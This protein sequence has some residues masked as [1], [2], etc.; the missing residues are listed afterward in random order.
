A[1]SGLTRAG[2]LLVIVLGAASLAAS[3]PLAVLAGIALKVGIDIIDWGFLKRAHQISRKGALIMYG[4]I[5][6]TVLVDL[7]AAVGCGSRNPPSPS[8]FRP[9]RFAADRDGDR[10]VRQRCAT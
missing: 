8:A 4:V 9:D 1:L 2:V 3:I 5:I 10:R 7:I 6:L